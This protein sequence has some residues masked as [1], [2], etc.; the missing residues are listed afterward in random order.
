MGAYSISFTL[1]KASAEHG[2]NVQHNNRKFTAPNV[3][4]EKEKD[5]IY[6]KTQD[7]RE[8]Y[9]ELFD[10][11]VEEY[12]KKQSRPC[13]KIK[14]YFEHIN[15]GKREE[16]FYESVV[17][18]GNF[19]DSPCGSER[20][21]EVKQLLDEY[22]KEFQE[23]NPNLYVFNAVL[24]MDEASPH[25]H[26]DFIPYYTKGRVN[27]LSK[28]VSMKAAL[29]EQGFKTNSK[30]FNCLVSWEASERKAM[31]VILNRR[32]HNRED[33]NATYKHMSV[34]EYKI[35][36]DEQNIR[37]HLKNVLNVGST[38]K[39]ENTVRNLNIK[40]QSANQKINKLEK[41]K[42]SP[43]KS[44]FYSDSEKQA[45]VQNKMEENN[46]PFVETENG[47]DAQE[48]YV[49]KIRN[50]EH[51]YISPEKSN[52]K[53]LMEDIDRLIVT[54]DDINE[55]YKKLEELKYKIRFGKYVSV[56]PPLAERYIR[57]K[58]LGEDYNE[59]SL[60]NAIQFRI[61]FEQDLKEKIEQPNAEY[62]P[63]YKTLTTIR[64]YTVTFKKGFLPYQKMH[65]FKPFT[66]TNDEELDKLLLLNKKISEGETIESMKK[67]FELKELDYKEKDK[68]ADEA[69]KKYQRLVRGKEA[70]SVLY[71]GKE[72]K[73]ISKEQAEKFREAFPHITENNYIE[74]FAFTDQAKQDFDV[75]KSIAKE[76]EQELRSLSGAIAI[77]EQVDA[78]TYVQELVSK[79]NIH[80]N[81]DHL[82][83]GVFQL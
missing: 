13:R 56:K 68:A 31:E 55:L 19:D 29:A 43:H 27:G 32:G 81:A 30:N 63:N 18:F 54:C 59:R 10:E 58:S 51:E 28:G 6:Y 70:F 64:F 24:H 73:Y 41:E 42:S 15:E 53:K 4:P 76:A 33:M 67:E 45:F 62:L 14:N 11:A 71:E 77:A 60:Q 39:I 25:I 66:W 49:E 35:R 50:W 5:N 46:I 21:E 52:R 9:H 23:R 2:G 82:P 16:I 79:E 3:D 20:G 61:K 44:F 37:K 17:Q 74:L 40:L 34:E 75:A 48:C 7:I 38:D 22:M 72:S 65:K 57:L 26:I 47:F 36:K 8:A 1:G 80:R 83:N 69:M 78:G 12:N